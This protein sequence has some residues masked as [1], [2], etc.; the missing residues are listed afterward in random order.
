MNSEE[1]LNRVL[2]GTREEAMFFCQDRFSQSRH[3]FD[4]Q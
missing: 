1:E 3:D 2:F 4:V